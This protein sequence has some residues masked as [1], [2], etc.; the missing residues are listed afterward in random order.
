MSMV[1]TAGDYEAISAG[2]K[3]FE[4]YPR[5]PF[6][7]MARS[8]RAAF[9]ATLALLLVIACEDDPRRR[10]S[11]DAG[12]AD[13]STARDAQQPDFGTGPADLGPRDLGGPVDLGTDLGQDFGVDSGPEELC[14][15]TCS[16]DGD[17]D[18][19]DGGPGSD[20]S[21]CDYGTDCADCGP[22]APM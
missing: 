10:A 15:N 22:R 8:V 1:A 6:H 3:H 9:I 12:P 4:R 14:T 21:L 16:Y 20:F 7:G 13:L 11:Q 2:G 19:D 17:G 18:C 5:A